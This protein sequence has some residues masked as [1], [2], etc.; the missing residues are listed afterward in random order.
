VEQ[1]AMLQNGI[2]VVKY[3]QE[4]TYDEFIMESKPKKEALHIMDDK[5]TKVSKDWMHTCSRRGHLPPRVC[6]RA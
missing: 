6:T 2:H 3:I 1:I 4:R 5:G